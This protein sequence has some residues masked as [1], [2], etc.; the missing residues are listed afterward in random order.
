M[1]FCF[2]HASSS[3]FY[4]VTVHIISAVPDQPTPLT[5]RCQSKDDDFGN[6]T[7]YYRQEFLWRFVPDFFLGRT[8]FF[9]HFYWGSKQNIFDV[10]NDRIGLV[11]G[12]FSDSGHNCYVEAR[13]D[14]FYISRGHA[15]S[16]IFYKV[17][18]H[19][20]SAVSNQPTPLI[21]HCRTRD[22]DFGNHTLYKSQ[23]F[24]WRFVPDF[25]GR[26]VYF[27]HFYW[28][29]KQRVFDV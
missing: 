13:S 25:F 14:A 26:T 5:V 8:V 3:I 7:L 22:D 9:C 6:H 16:S 28:G 11:C 24:V 18:V 29:S 21:A 4:K 17:T 15:S 12:Q 23:E 10:Y 2:G 27:C 1:V 20:I 19:I